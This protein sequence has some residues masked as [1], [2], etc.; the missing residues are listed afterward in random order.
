LKW[1][2]FP[3]FGVFVSASPAI[4]CEIPIPSADIPVEVEYRPIDAGY[5][6]VVL[7]Y[8]AEFAELPFTGVTLS[9]RE[10]DQRE[11]SI[12]V[13]VES[14]TSSFGISESMIRTTVVEVRYGP[15]TPG[16]CPEL[17]QIQLRLP[18]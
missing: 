8:P 16:M 10:G 13:D 7:R 14:T 5:Y 6:R 11:L 12:P 18:E 15:E 4:G 1:I 17:R 2:Y 9:V 3:V